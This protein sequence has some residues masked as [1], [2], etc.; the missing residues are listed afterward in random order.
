MKGLCDTD[1]NKRQSNIVVRNEYN[2][3]YNALDVTHT[4]T[5]PQSS[6]H[7]AAYIAC[8][9]TTQ[10]IVYGETTV[11][12]ANKP[13]ALFFIARPFVPSDGKNYYVHSFCF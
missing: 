6:Q 10:I 9:A 5:H 4:H 13:R 7:I 12:K 3:P 8:V 2:I 1:D 11:R